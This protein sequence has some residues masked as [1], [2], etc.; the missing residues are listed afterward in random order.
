[1]VKGNIQSQNHSLSTTVRYIT[2]LEQDTDPDWN[3]VNMR[4]NRPVATPSCRTCHSVNS[5]L[6]EGHWGNC[7]V[8]KVSMTKSGRNLS[9]TWHLVSPY[10]YYIVYQTIHI[11]LPL[12]CMTLPVTLLQA[13]F[14]TIAKFVDAPKKKTLLYSR[15]SI[16]NLIR[17]CILVLLDLIYWVWLNA[18]YFE[19]LHAEILVIAL[20]CTVGLLQNYCLPF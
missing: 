19:I 8:V 17:V 12:K 4:E 7:S 13:Q 9:R 11:L 20:L 10:S 2:S 18:V 6:M 5:F 14:S 3:Q 15:T 1:M 16:V